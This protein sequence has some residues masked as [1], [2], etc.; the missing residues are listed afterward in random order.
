ML[1]AE[2]Q[3]IRPYWLYGFIPLTILV[4]YMFRHKLRNKKWESLCDKE[5]LPYILIGDEPATRRTSA[6]ITL[7]AGTIVLLSLAGPTWE[8]LPQPVFSTQSALVIALDL[9]RSMDATDVNPSRLERARFKVADILQH[10]AE[11]ETALLVYAGDSFTVTP[12]TDD[13]ATIESQLMALTTDIIP[14]QG[15]RTDL[16][17]SKAVELLKQA[18]AG[19]GDVLLIT[20]EIDFDRNR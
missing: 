13:A 17:M 19:Q 11:G 10:R 7:V 1:P 3:F 18:G 4:L 9:S 8:K 12:L 16:A 15:N 6:M 5:L 2:F 20:D 14:A